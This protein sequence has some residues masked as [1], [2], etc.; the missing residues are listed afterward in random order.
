MIISTFKFSAEVWKV[1]TRV[2]LETYQI[3]GIERPS[4]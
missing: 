1:V 2:A 4:L 3:V